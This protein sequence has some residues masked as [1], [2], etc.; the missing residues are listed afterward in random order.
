MGA[1]TYGWIKKGGGEGEVTGS[2]ELEENIWSCTKTIFYISD[3]LYDFLKLIFFAEENT[4][5]SDMGVYVEADRQGSLK[6]QSIISV[7]NR[8]VKQ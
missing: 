1:N 4:K 5:Q 3:W 6:T 8:T 2:E 7:E